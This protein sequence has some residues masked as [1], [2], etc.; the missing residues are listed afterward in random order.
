MEFRK[1]TNAG[2]GD[3]Q[4]SAVS[5]PISYSSIAIRSR[6]RTGEGGQGKDTP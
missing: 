1:G 6:K 5:V 3:I 2:P 4:Y